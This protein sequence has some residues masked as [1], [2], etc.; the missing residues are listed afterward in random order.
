MRKNSLL[1]SNEG[2]TLIEILVGML[3]F[4]ILMLTISMIMY[5][6]L[7][8]IYDT[9]KLSE[10][11]IFVDDVANQ[12]SNEIKLANKIELEPSSS[13]ESSEKLILYN[14][15]NKISYTIFDGILKVNYNDEKNSK[16]E[17]VYYDVVS[18]KYYDG[19]KLE[20]LYEPIKKDEK[21]VGCRFT[22]KV[23]SDGKMVFKKTYSALSFI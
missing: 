22:T 7:N 15:E 18:K 23:V 16:S 17:L 13:P 2:F 1:K 8:S 5:P 11:G 10:Y 19:N 21:I 20:I 4:G 12:I 9:K 3:I 6:T 14:S